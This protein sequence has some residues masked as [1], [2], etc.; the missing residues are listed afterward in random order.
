MIVLSLFKLSQL[1]VFLCTPSKEGS[2]HFVVSFAE[3]ERWQD[4]Q[5]YFFSFR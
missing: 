1:S 4:M 5:Q 2:F 3:E